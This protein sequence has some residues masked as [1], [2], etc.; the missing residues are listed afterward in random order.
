MGT[1]SKNS[2]IY[3]IIFT[4]AV[5]L[6][7]Y[8][9]LTTI[10]Y[11]YY[12][13]ELSVKSYFKTNEFLTRLE[14]SIYDLQEYYVTYSNYD[15]KSLDEKITKEELEQA[16]EDHNREVEESI[17]SIK[18]HYKYEIYNSTAEER[19]N[20]IYQRDEAI[21][22]YEKDN[23]M[24]EEEIKAKLINRKNQ[25]YEQLKHNVN[26]WKSLKYYLINK[27]NGE[28]YTNLS[29]NVDI[30][31]YLKKEMIYCDKYPKQELT[32]SYI[33]DNISRGLASM[34]LEG[35]FFI[36]KEGTGYSEFYISDLQFTNRNKRII[37]EVKL[38]AVAFLMSIILFIIVSRRNKEEKTILSSLTHSYVRI[39]MEIRLVLLGI[40]AFIFAVLLE[41]IRE[42]HTV[43]YWIYIIYCI[44]WSLFQFYILLHVRGIYHLFVNSEFLKSQWRE[45]LVCR[46]FRLIFDILSHMKILY[47][48]TIV[49]ISSM[50][51]SIAMILI[52]KGYDS[53]FTVFSFLYIV[54]YLCLVYLFVY[55][56]AM[57]FNDVVKGANSIAA[58]NFDLVIEEK[59][60]DQIRVLA[61][62]FNNIK[63]GYKAAMEKQIKSE[64]LKT[65]LITNVSHDLKTPL[66]S[67]INY[68]DLLK[69]KELSEE[70][71][72][73]YIEI[74]DRKAQ[75]LK[76]LIEDLFEASK[77]SSGA[78][79]LEREQVDIAAIL[80]QTL[81]E[82][83]EKINK[84]AL[85]FRTNIPSDKIYLYLDGK[86]TWRV[87]ENLINNAL[88]YSQPNTRVYIDLIESESS[89]IF[90]IKNISNY[91]MDFDPE[92]IFERFKRG[93]KSRNTEGSGL[94]LAIARSIVEL[95]GGKMHIEID[96][97]LFKVIVE[98]K[99]TEL[100]SS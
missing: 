22:N 90:T 49:L 92:E 11:C 63:N 34:N 39:P 18:N 16:I 15:K 54:A 41:S 17:E 100:L 76:I 87:F 21:K 3:S 81:G 50:F 2:F 37:T 36:P 55:K 88:K 44:F 95:Q 99:K 86:K 96:G 82:L 10:V 73:S 43:P 64:R 98:F 48:L 60:K 40:A 58:G 1:K 80:R 20:Y 42:I 57:Y 71:K 79:E 52:I 7:G 23:R 75:R 19:Q 56:R 26:Q 28:I 38:G 59:G 12:Y 85:T 27:T 31:E 72:D 46:F 45:T 84:S 94:G 89:V 33:E 14:S 53:V 51:F 24:S 91:E 77:M 93:D 5:L 65:E 35:Y 67:I 9:T 74:L 70:E 68:V 61:Q 13:D 32:M 8:S 66:T 29:N 83:D 97:D 69:N 6:L 62:N 30:N 25:I 78:I 4:L 47:K